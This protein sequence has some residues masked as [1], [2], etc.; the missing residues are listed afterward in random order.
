MP[1]K[2]QK[3]K[4]AAPKTSVRPKARPGS[5]NKTAVARG[6]KAADRR[7]KEAMMDKKAGKK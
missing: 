1:A 2:G 7:N 3:Y 4:K 5:T 6:N